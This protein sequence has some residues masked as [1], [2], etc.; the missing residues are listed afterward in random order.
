MAFT[1][2][3][4]LVTH[5]EREWILI[6]MAECCAAK[7]YE[8]ATVADV[9]AAAGISNKS[10]ARAFATKSECL[11][12]TMESIVEDAWRALDRVL[13]P[14]K[15]WGAELRDG[16]ATLLALLAERPAF[17]H[18]ALIEAPTAGGQAAAL[19]GSS[20]AAL[21]AFLERGMESAEPGVPASAAAGALAGVETLVTGQI[22]AGKADRLGELILDVVYMLAVPFVGRGEAQRLAAG[23]A[24]RGH[25][26]AVA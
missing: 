26:R 2:M 17:A 1:T 9:C 7:S 13:S 21:L 3:Q 8:A 14:D 24:R 10:F 11:G 23:P 20:R 19:A 6:G 4:P 5:S 22:L 15:P 12:A 18:V 16:A 25:L